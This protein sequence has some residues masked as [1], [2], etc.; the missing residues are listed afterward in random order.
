MVWCGSDCA[1][2]PAERGLERSTPSRARN[3]TSTS[4]A[5][6]AGDSCANIPDTQAPD[7]ISKAVNARKLIIDRRVGHGLLRINCVRQ[8]RQYLRKRRSR[9][10]VQQSSLRIV[11]FDGPS[12]SG[13]EVAFRWRQMLRVPRRHRPYCRG[14]RDR[15][16]TST[17]SDAGGELCPEAPELQTIER[18]SKTT[19]ALRYDEHRGRKSTIDRTV[20]RRPLRINCAP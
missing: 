12:L 20:S 15:N 16:A 4:L 6:A 11:Q 13:R 19:G 5:A 1:L 7:S 3:A 9:S 8:H 2:P 17:S 18:T 10:S 14:V